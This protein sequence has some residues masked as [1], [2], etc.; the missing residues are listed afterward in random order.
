MAKYYK[1]IKSWYKGASRNN[2]VAQW[3]SAKPQTE[4]GIS[5]KD[6]KSVILWHSLKVD[7]VKITFGFMG[8]QG[9]LRN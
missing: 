5:E 7:L 3:L 9:L 1:Y 2:P 4:S 8:V 6:P